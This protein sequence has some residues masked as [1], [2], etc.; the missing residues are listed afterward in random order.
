MRD[1][2]LA[3][4]PYPDTPVAH[5]AAGPL[6]G[7][8]FGVKDL[9]DVEGYPT[10][11]GNP[12][13]LARS[14][15]A[16]RTAPAVTALLD[17]GAEFGG[18]TQTDE[19]AWSM[20]GLNTYFGG[21]AIPAAP[22]RITGGSSCGSA[23]AVAGGLV[24]LRARDRYGRL[25][26]RAG[27]VLRD[28]GVPPDLGAISIDGCMPL[29]PGF[30][31]CGIFAR[32]G[33]VL[34]RVAEVMLG[35][36]AAPVAGAGVSAATDMFARVAPEAM[37][38]LRPSAAMLSDGETALYVEDAEVFHD[39]FDTLQSSARS[40]RARALGSRRTARRSDRWW[41]PGTRRRLRS[42]SRRN[43]RRW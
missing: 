14:G 20:V 1:P 30:D 17:A 37:E 16:A 12:V 36:D 32:E 41:R 27:G 19:I 40:W 23:A 24:G 21:T 38:A 26:A 29:A 8:R 25:G 34:A 42:R 4:M 43:G 39:C 15:I 18:K 5:A 22:D 13:K 6:A 10:G 28:L 31:T 33:A 35:P 7:L 11:C 2:Y 3:F 9:F